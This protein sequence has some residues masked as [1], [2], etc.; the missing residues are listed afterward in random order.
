MVNFN[1]SAPK[2]SP[3]RITK[4]DDI[5]KPGTNSDIATAEYSFFHIHQ[6][7]AWSG[8]SVNQEEID[9]TIDPPIYLNA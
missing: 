5:Q 9:Y 1:K 7:K 3:G 6:I 8:W 2:N 4:P